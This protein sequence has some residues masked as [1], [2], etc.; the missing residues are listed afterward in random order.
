MK[1]VGQLVTDVS[2]QLNDQY[3]G[4]EFQRWNRARLLS[5][6]VGGMAEL[7]SYKP[8]AFTK[9][10]AVVLAAGAKQELTDKYKT[11][12]SV[13]SNTDGSTVTEADFDLFK[14]YSPYSCCAAEVVFDA[15]NNPIY[16]AKSFAIDPKDPKTFY[17]SPPVPVGLTPTIN[18]IAIVPPPEYTLAD[19]GVELPFDMK[20]QENILD[21]MMGRAFDIDTES[22]MSRSNA[23]KHLSRFYT[24][25]GVKYR[26]ESAYRAGNYNGSIG[27]GDPRARIT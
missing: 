12:V 7:L 11:I 17:V 14:A 27:D 21:Y 19:W 1:T 20:Y 18:V 3:L 5:Y 4:R 25:M 2:G 24:A 16:K 26:V 13:A 10:E 9:T 6:L 23:D 8:E 15:N 22:A